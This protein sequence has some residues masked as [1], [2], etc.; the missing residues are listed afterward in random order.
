MNGIAL[1]ELPVS[2]R[3]AL[4]LTLLVALGGFVA[5]GLH[6][7]EHHE[8]R[9]GIEGMSMDDIKGAYHG[10]RSDSRLRLAIE[11]NHPAEI[12]GATA[13]PAQQKAGL[14][15]WLAS[16]NLATGYDNLDLGDNAPAEVLTNYCVDCH[17]ATS[18]DPV[19]KTMP[20]EYYEQVEPFAIERNVSP[21]DTKILLA[22]THTHALALATLSLVLTGLL[23]FTRWPARFRGALIL[24]VSVGL[25]ADLASW[26]LARSTAAFA[27]LIAGAGTVF[28]VGSVLM[29]LAV[30]AD[31]W[32][33]ADATYD[34][35]SGKKNE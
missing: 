27:Y 3:L 14:L 34:S 16:S 10:I 12:A 20:L 6:L 13:L 31:L 9:D 18:K 22:S 32:R 29:I 4:T 35:S 5:S 19:A 2:V 17:S 15:K 26:W 21:T 1:R 33:P 30:I 7:V 28:G 11:R 25:F 24:A 8:N 23:W